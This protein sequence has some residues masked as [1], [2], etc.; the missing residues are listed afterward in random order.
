LAICTA[1]AIKHRYSIILQLNAYRAT[2]LNDI[3]DFSDY[4]VKIYTNVTRKKEE[5]KGRPVE[6]AYMKQIQDKVRYVTQKKG[7]SHDRSLRFNLSKTYPRDRVLLYAYGGGGKPLLENA[8]KRERHLF[9]YIRFTKA[10]LNEYERVKQAAKIPERYIAIHLRA[11]DMPL[12]ISSSVEGASEKEESGIKEIKSPKDSH[13]EALDKVSAFI[14]MNPDTPVYIASDNIRLLEKVKAR[15]GNIVTTYSEK[16]TAN[17]DSNRSC[18]RI[19]AYNSKDSS[20]LSGAVID[21]LLLANAKKL[22]TSAGGFSRLAAS[23]WRRK[24]LVKK[25]IRR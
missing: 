25:L 24:E 21:L 1:Y 3:F 10:F 19:H 4:P 16:N 20:I 13:T 15:H 9:E 23:L 17:C 7:A 11:T 8:L 6:P 2:H 5:L 18:K 12:E 14:E 22:M